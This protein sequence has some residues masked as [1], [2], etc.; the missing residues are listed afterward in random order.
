MPRAHLLVAAATLAACAGCRD[1]VVIDNFAVVADVPALP[2]RDL[3]IL[4]VIDNSPSM[5]SKQLALAQNFPRM[6]D[7]LAS[8]DGGLPDLHVGVVTSDMGTSAD[9]TAP[10]PNVGQPGISGGCGGAGDD[11]AL[12]VGTAELTGGLTYISDV[13]SADGTTRDRNYTGALG[14]VF[15]ALA[16]VGE[17]GCGYEQHLRAMRRALTNPRNA[18]FVRPTANLAVVLVADEDDCSLS[19]ASLFDPN[20]GPA[21]GPMASYRCTRFG[22]RCDPDDPTVPHALA[23]CGPRADSP[24]VDD[25]QPFVDFLTRFKADPRMVM[26]SAIVAD[27]S[28]VAT[29]MRAPAAGAPPE[30]ALAHAC[31]FVES[32]GTPAVADPAVRLA[33]FL[34][35]FPDR[36]TLT[37]ICSADLGDPLATVGASA[38]RLVGD[39]CLAAPALAD[40]SPAPGLQ[41]ICHVLDMRAAGPTGGLPIPPC[42][43]TVSD[44]CYAFVADATACPAAPGHLRL[45]RRRSSAGAADEWT[46]VRCKLP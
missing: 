2:N 4:F 1:D 18:G 30:I 15:S 9:L 17:Q 12:H 23:A 38:R 43:A 6:L 13:A 8:L 39:P 10:A 42:S 19:D 37:S 27:P 45:V 24:Y 41:P 26:V 14:D 32:D 21:L 11:G 20:N 29:E 7:R 40:T 22:I 25:V 33:A 28:P 36:S 16:T 35:G 3:D 44:N 46:E 34:D 5:A 31:A